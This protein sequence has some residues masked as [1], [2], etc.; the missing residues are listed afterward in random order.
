MYK[1]VQSLWKTCKSHASFYNC[2]ECMHLCR[3]V[4]FE[5]NARMGRIFSAWNT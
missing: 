4:W 1:L 5:L 3:F 2:N